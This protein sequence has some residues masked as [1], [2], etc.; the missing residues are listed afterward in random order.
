MI[1]EKLVF[2]STNP[3]KPMSKEVHNDLL[4]FFREDIKKLSQLLELN[5]DKWMK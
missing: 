2:L 4:L 5:L 1:Q 3:I